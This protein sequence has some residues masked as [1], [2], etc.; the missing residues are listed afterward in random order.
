VTEK[1]SCSFDDLITTNELSDFRH[2]WPGQ[3]VKP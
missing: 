3:T 2:P 1:D